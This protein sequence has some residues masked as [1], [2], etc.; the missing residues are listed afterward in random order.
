MIYGVSNLLSQV[1]RAVKSSKKSRYRLWK[2]T[3]IAQSQLSRL[4]AGK[5]GLSYGNLEKLVAALG[6][7]IILRPKRSARRKDG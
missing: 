5:E 3:E 2:E 7:E 4:M 6:L 1:R